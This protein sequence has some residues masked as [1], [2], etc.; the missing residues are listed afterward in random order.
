[1]A[2]S[3]CQ[4]T[5]YVNPLRVA[6]RGNWDQAALVLHAVWSVTV[7]EQPK[8]VG[9]ESYRISRDSEISR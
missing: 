6:R 4:N 3:V 9:V 2:Q 5:D 1:M 8:R 7:D